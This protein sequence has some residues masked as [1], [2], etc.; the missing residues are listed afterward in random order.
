M[1]ASMV[2]E[3]VDRMVE[4]MAVQLAASMVVEMVALMAE[5]MAV[6]KALM[7]VGS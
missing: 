5:L 2:V 4:L 1:A 7:K 3:I 6:R